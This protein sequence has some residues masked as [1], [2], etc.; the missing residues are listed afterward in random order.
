MAK[1]RKKNEKSKIRRGEGYL[2]YM[3]T[4]VYG[5]PPQ[6]YFLKVVE[7]ASNSGVL[8]TIQEAAQGVLEAAWMIL[9]PTAD[10]RARK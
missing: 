8:E 4:V 2:C 3:S 5:I 1:I 10:E 7:L 9:L 6:I